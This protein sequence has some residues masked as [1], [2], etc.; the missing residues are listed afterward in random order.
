M[1][2]CSCHSCRSCTFSRRRIQNRI[3]DHKTIEGEM[4]FIGLEINKL[5]KKDDLEKIYDIECENLVN[6]SEI[7]TEELDNIQKC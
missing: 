7:Q 6:S 1:G 2:R 4:F 5:E 3:S